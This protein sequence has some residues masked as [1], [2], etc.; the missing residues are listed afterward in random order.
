MPGSRLINAW[1]AGPYFLPCRA[2]AS[3]A[4]GFDPI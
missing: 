2:A 3:P 4:Q 1:C